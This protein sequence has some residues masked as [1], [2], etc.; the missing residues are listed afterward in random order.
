MA[1]EKS[2]THTCDVFECLAISAETV[3]GP[4]QPEPLPGMS[5]AQSQ[6]AL[7]VFASRDLVSL[8][9][10]RGT[11]FSE[12]HLKAVIDPTGQKGLFFE[13]RLTRYGEGVVS[14]PS[15]SVCPG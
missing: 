2:Q 3:S 11:A 6:G 15:G 14:S 12:G 1:A 4:T 8:I 5:T 13:R 7:E 10:A 9:V